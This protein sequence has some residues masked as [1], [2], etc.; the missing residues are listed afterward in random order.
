M[1]VKLE[2]THN[3]VDKHGILTPLKD[4]Q[5]P[6]Y[7]KVLLLNSYYLEIITCDYYMS[8]PIPYY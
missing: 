3:V 8:S 4:K 2:L 7:F 5:P 1:Y 6:K